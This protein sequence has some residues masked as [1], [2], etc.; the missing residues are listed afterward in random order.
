MSQYENSK[1]IFDITLNGLTFYAI[2]SFTSYLIKYLDRVNQTK[3][4][5]AQTENS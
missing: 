5:N 4:K 1:N 3:I 2:I